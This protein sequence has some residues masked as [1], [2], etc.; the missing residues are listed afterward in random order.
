MA[1][2]SPA[3]HSSP[4]S[5][6]GTSL[7]L[8]PCHHPLVSLHPGDCTETVQAPSHPALQ[9]ERATRPSPGRIGPTSA[10]HEHSPGKKEKKGR[11]DVKG[12]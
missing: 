3:T 4:V 9:E 6:T 11:N 7:L 10:L 8:R 12:E 5:P 2:P 1:L